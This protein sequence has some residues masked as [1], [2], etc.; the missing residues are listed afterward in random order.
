MATVDRS[1]YPVRK[2][3]LE[4]EGADSGVDKLTTSERVTL[5]WQLTKQ[6]WT[7]KEGRWD[8]PRLRR[9]VVRTLRGGR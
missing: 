3:R 8:E 7:F 5:V 9:D 4:D 6:A 2:I 1:G